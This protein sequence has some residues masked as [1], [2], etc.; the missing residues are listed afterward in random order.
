MAV[1]NKK[2]YTVDCDGTEIEHDFEPELAENGCWYSKE[3]RIVPKGTYTKMTRE[4]PVPGKTKRLVVY[5]C[6]GKL[7][8]FPKPK[9][10]WIARDPSYFNP[11]NDECEGKLRLFY[12]TPELLHNSQTGHIEWGMAREIA[13]I[14]TYMFP[15]VTDKN[16]PRVFTLNV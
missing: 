15:E 8:T 6:D 13:I 11:D 7:G 5:N 12:D 2:W 4:Y 16:S 14:P 1:N 10:I 9:C 3:G